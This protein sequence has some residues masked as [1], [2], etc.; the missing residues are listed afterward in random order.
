MRRIAALGLVLC[1]LAPLPGLAGPPD[2]VSTSI[3]PHTSAR[4]HEGS[5][6][7]VPAHD[8]RKFA[9][10]LAKA[11]PRR[12]QPAETRER[13]WISRHPVLFGLILGAGAGAVAAATMDNELFCGG[14]D[15]D[16]VFYGGGRVL[17]GAGI[18]AGAGAAVGAL[19][20]LGRK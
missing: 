3:P 14:T 16:C 4:Q 8:V 7:A 20:G 17:V 2:R 9:A 6:R 15:E 19:V 18:G 1:V 11:E 13:G 10:T 12:V 5:L